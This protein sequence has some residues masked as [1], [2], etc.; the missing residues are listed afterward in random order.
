[1]TGH[2]RANDGAPRSIIVSDREH[3]LPYSKGL[4]SNTIMATGLTPSRAYHIAHVIEERLLA[5]GRASV[6]TGELRDI[7]VE[8]LNAEAGERYGRSFLRWQ[9]VSELDVPLIILIGGGTGV[10]KSTIATQLAARLGIVRI[11][12]TDAIREVMKG[13]FSAEI[14]PTLH[15]SSFSTDEVIRAKLS[16]SDD[17]VI[18]GFR[19][20]VSAV[21]VGIQALIERAITEG[22]D[23]I[24]E[25]AHVVPG[26]VKPEGLGDA[27]IVHFVV[28]VDD[29]AL[30]RS[31]FY[32]RAH[33]TRSRPMDRYL[34]YFPN[35]RRIQKYI[36]SLA[37]QNG[38]PIIQNYNLDA[39]I[40][41]V[42][43]HVVTRATEDATKRP[44]ARP[45]RTRTARRAAGGGRLKEE[46]R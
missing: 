41:T 3:G 18:V 14:M 1:M 11:M 4:M 38:A 23:L 26:F 21:A 9:M 27:V 37:L 24:I 33:E 20:Q 15:T 22:T 2:D 42:I 30:H 35:I 28:A 31:H 10:G 44:A 39:T 12:S 5:S 32:V 7:A 19:E 8:V 25:G 43:E 13:V 17:A 36:K 46:A 16:A 45:R 34:N 29:E 40:A 6:T